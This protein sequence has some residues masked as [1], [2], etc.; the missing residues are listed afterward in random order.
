MNSAVHR[1]Y[2]GM[3]RKLPRRRGRA[4]ESLTMIE[5]HVAIEVLELFGRYPVRI[6]VK[7]FLSNDCVSLSSRNRMRATATRSDQNA[8]SRSPV[9]QRKEQRQS[10]AGEYKSQK[11]GSL[12]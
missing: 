8:E 12:P 2:R 5:L 1:G 9:R 4:R 7:D 3:H 10:T 6:L 11:I